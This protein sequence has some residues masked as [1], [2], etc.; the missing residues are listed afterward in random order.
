MDPKAV[1]RVE[2]ELDGFVEKR[3][4][5]AKD[6]ER[7]QELWAESERRE[8]EKRR[9]ENEWG[10]IKH[11]EGL[12]FVHRALALENDNKAARVRALLGDTERR[13]SQ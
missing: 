6:A 3:A 12:A 4:R 13:K 8:R 5:Q 7:V 9:Q 10:W 2:A 1:E 11:Y